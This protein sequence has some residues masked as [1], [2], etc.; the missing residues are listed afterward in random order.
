MA[1]LTK[2][3]AHQ[4][5]ASESYDTEEE[6]LAT[7]KEVEQRVRKHSW[8]F[9][10]NRDDTTEFTFSN[11]NI[12]SIETK[13]GTSLYKKTDFT[14][15]SDGNIQTLIKEYFDENLQ[16]YVKMKKDFLFDSDGNI[17]NIQN[18]ILT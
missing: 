10:G 4:T 3:R 6:N 17:Q 2:L 16:S 8:I 11:D 9:H 1:R 15:D 12:Q 5:R 7:D 13:N 18:T 14:F